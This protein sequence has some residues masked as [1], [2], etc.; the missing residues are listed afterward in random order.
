MND[1]FDQSPY[2]RFTLRGERLIGEL[3]TF[4]GFKTIKISGR[5]GPRAYQR[6]SE[7]EKIEIITP[8]EYFLDRLK[9]R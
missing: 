3:V 4:A 7:L 6:P 5:N 2:R 9:G 8:E 1:S